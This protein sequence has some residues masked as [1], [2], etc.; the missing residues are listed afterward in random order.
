MSEHVKGMTRERFEYAS[1][2]VYRLIKAMYPW[3]M[4]VLTEQH[5]R[6]CGPTVQ[7]GGANS[8]TFSFDTET[9]RQGDNVDRICIWRRGEK[10]K[11]TIGHDFAIIPKFLDNHGRLTISA[12]NLI[13]WEVMRL[14]GKTATRDVYEELGL[15]ARSKQEEL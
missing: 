8:L 12:W 1:N 7:C 5:E 10:S 3:A 9:N 14:C 15:N 11:R 4:P 6:Y 13:Q 2:V